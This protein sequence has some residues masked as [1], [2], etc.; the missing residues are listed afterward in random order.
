MRRRV[1][2]TLLGGAAAWPLAARAQQAGKVHRIGFL[3]SAT[4]AGSAKAVESLRT[5]LR[6]FGYVESTNI[7]IEF[8][9]AEGIYDRLPHLVAELIATNVDVLITH[10]TP[11]TRV[12]KQ[13]TTTI[14]I[15]MAISGDAIATGL[16]SSLARPEA[17]LTGST[18][19]LPQLNAKRLEL[20]KEACPRIS[21]ISEAFLVACRRGDRIVWPMSEFGTLLP[22][23]NAAA[24]PQLAKADRNIR[25][26][27]RALLCLPS[28]RG[29]AQERR[30][31]PNRRG[32]R[33]IQSA[34]AAPD[35]DAYKSACSM[36]GSGP[37]KGGAS[38]RNTRWLPAARR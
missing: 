9:W 1:F 36:P 20:L 32:S 17:N 37:A 13:A 38:G 11:G 4:A 19:F 26:N 5:G 30:A 10:G 18:F 2:I 21:P 25:P 15:V 28:A 8:R 7:G 23:A 12:A 27:R 29:N 16:V 14:P 33:K 31:A 22:R 35:L 34:C 6:E 24:C 3:G